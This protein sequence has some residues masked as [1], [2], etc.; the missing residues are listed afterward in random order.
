MSN[1]CART[2][3]YQRLASQALVPSGNNCTTWS[4]TNPTATASRPC[5]ATAT[6]VR[7]SWRPAS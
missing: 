7:T 5:G 6:F 4:R 3:F 2:A 1:D